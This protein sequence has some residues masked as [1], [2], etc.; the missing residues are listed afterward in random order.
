M[1]KKISYRSDLLNDLR[2]DIG[3]AAKYLSAA[4]ADSQEAFLVALRDVAEAKKMANVA[5]AANISRESLYRTLSK[6]GNPRFSTL[7]SVLDALGMTLTVQ[8]KQ[9]VVSQSAP[10]APSVQG[11]DQTIATGF[12]LNGN[13]SITSTTTGF[14]NVATV[15]SNLTLTNPTTVSPR[16]Q[17]AWTYAGAFMPGFIAHATIAEQSTNNATGD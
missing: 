6:E 8:P 1:I 12:D 7:D 9:G 5:E 16:E 14:G 3:Y 11:G 4:I 2:N 17:S 15:R 13:I 10:P